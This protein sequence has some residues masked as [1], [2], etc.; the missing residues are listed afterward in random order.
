MTEQSVE[1][2]YNIEGRSE[3]AIWADITSISTLLDTLGDLSIVA[4]YDWAR[5][6]FQ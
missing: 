3:A 4:T 5:A 6:N 2:Q 1:N